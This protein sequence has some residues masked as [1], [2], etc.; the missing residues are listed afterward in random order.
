MCSMCS[1]HHNVLCVSGLGSSGTQDLAHGYAWPPRKG[2]FTSSA[3]WSI[4]LCTDVL[5]IMD[6]S[7]DADHHDVIKVHDDVHDDVHD[8][9]MML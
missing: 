9:L 2:T 3:D 1:Q 8:E 7:G 4:L 6:N 5:E